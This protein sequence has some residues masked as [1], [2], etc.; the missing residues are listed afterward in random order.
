[1][2][3]SFKLK[4][5]D[6]NPKGESPIYLRMRFSDSNNK[7]TESSIFTG[8]EVEPKHFKNGN[9]IIRTPNYSTKRMML[10]SIV[11]YV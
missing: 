1:M 5:Q 8:V 10:D 11:T 2:N 4:T 6:V 9:L 7:I 3:L